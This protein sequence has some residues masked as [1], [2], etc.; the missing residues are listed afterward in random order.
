MPEGERRKID[1][2]ITRLDG[3]LSKLVQAATEVDAMSAKL[4]IAQAEVEKKTAEVK[5]MLEEISVSA[6]KAEDR[7][8]AASEKEAQLEVESAKIAEDKAEAEAA[9]EEA[10]P[11]LEEAAQA[12]NDLKKDDITELRSFAKPHQLVQDV[13]LCVVIL[14]GGKDVT[15]K[16]A[17]AMMTDTGFLRS[18]IEF[19]KDGLNDR[20]VKQVKSY[21]SNTAFTPDAVSTISSAGAGL[22]KWVFAIVNYY[23]VAKTVNPKRQAVANGEKMLRAAQKELSKIQAEVQQLSAQLLELKDKFEKG[24]A[25]ERDLSEKA[26]LMATRL[27]A[28]SKLITGLGSER[29]RWTSDMETLNATREYL[30]GDCLLAAAFLLHG[31][32]PSTSATL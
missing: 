8:K 5:V 30:V 22:L 17:K 15:W 10:L 3:G 20:Q 12:L 11:A 25:E 24:S 31:R 2:L 6:A 4:K 28:A 7:Q 18:L 1:Q 29:T 9:L 27:A 19:E 14:K 16:G 32:V 13:C 21:M 23:A 26:T